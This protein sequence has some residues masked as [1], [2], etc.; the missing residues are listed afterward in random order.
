[1]GRIKDFYEKEIAQMALERALRSA[2]P[3]EDVSTETPEQP[4]ANQAKGK[5][6][7]TE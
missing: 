4:P 2:H 3:A 6:A 5:K 7:G 1:M